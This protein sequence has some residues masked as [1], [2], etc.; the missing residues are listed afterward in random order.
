MLAAILGEGKDLVPLKRLIINKTEGNP[1]FMEEIVQAL[2]E[3]SALV[4][5][6]EIKAT[7]S[8]SEIQIPVT[9][10]AILAARIDRLPP[11]QKDLLQDTRCHRQGVR[12]AAGG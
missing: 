10:Q 12:G 8:L 6:G 1:F 7:R 3:D 4:R 9:V 11:D 5:N 2:F